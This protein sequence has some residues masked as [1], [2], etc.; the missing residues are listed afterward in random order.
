MIVLTKT[1]FYKKK[2]YFPGDKEIPE[3]VL[4]AALKADCAVQ[5]KD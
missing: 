4:K 1:F 2:W 5:H 3:E